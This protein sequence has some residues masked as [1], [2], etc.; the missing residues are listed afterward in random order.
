MRNLKVA[1]ALLGKS[2]DDIQIDL[3]KPYKQTKLTND[4]MECLWIINKNKKLICLFDR[5][6]VCLDYDTFRE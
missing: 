1:D 3:G 4:A 6:N 2:Y 5:N